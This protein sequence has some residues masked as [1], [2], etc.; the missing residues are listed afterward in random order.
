MRRLLI[1]LTLAATGC[2]YE[3]EVRREP[4]VT[5][6]PPPPSADVQPDSSYQTEAPPPPAGSEV[7]DDDVFY[8]GLAPYGSWTIVAPY[9]RVW[10][11]PPDGSRTPS[12]NQV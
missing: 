8:Q 11:P 10:I 4:V 9:G 5:A 3:S 1:V 7:A 12:S 6:P 2:L